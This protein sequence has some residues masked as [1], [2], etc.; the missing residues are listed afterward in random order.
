MAILHTGLLLLYIKSF[1]DQFQKCHANM[2]W[3][4]FI[5]YINF[6]DHVFFFAIATVTRA[7]EVWCQ[8]NSG[9]VN[10]KCLNVEFLKAY[11]RQ[12]QAGGNKWTFNP[13]TL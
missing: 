4:F 11:N 6:C 3:R 7:Y 10:P 5:S 12:I 13:D 2:S 9:E 8:T 1:Y